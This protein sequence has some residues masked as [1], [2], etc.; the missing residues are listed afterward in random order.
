MLQI[1]AQFVWCAAAQ[2]LISIFKSLH[3]AEKNPT[4]KRMWDSFMAEKERFELSKP[5][6]GLHDFQSCALGQL[7]DFSS[8]FVAVSMTAWI[9]YYRFSQL[10]T[11]KPKILILIFHNSAA[12]EI[13]CHDT[14]YNIFAG[15]SEKGHDL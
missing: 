15:H 14:F 3:S 13:P 11:P 12:G 2:H 1:A 4:S 5:L 8:W 9:S 7:R 10:S 6:W